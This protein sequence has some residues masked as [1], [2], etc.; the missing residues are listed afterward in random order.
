MIFLT[1]GGCSTENFFDINSSIEAP[2]NFSEQKNI[3]NC[4]KNC[5][6]EDVKPNYALYKGRYLSC[7]VGNFDSDDLLGED[8]ALFFCQKPPNLNEMHI[9]FLRKTEGHWNLLK[10]A[11]HFATDVEKVYIQDVDGDGNNEF[12]FVLKGLDKKR[13]SVYTY[14]YSGGNVE[15]VNIPQTFF[16][17]FEDNN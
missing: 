14:R 17:N 16:N 9:L 7:I 2:T 5:I 10:D 1:F 6:G 3:L 13:D 11:K 4:V 8:F 12:A 15:K